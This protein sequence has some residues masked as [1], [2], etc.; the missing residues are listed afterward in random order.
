MVKENQSPA[1]LDMQLLLDFTEHL[2][3]N[4]GLQ[5]VPAELI[6]DA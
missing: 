4:A 2:H 3:R 6:C 5:S 1:I